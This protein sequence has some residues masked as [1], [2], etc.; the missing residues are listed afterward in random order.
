[1]F[2]L[3]NAGVSDDEI[4]LYRIWIQVYG[5]DHCPVTLLVNF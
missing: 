1:M 4:K 2:Q 5:S 3:L